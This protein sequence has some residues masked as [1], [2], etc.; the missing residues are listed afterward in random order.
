MPEITSPYNFVPPPEQTVY[1]AWAD[2]VSHDIPFAD[3]ICGWIE[4]EVAATTDLFV[5]GREGARGETATFYRDADGTLA[6]PGSGLRGMLR[7]VVEIAS[8][9]QLKPFNDQRFGFRDLHN[10]EDYGRHMAAIIGGEPMPLV[11][12]GWL[13]RTHDEEAGETWRIRPCHYAKAEY[14][15]LNRLAQ[16]L[17]VR[18]FNPDDKQS[19]VK[20]YEA[21]GARAFDDH[22]CP[23]SIKMRGGQ[24]LQGVKRLSDVGQVGLGASQL[25]RLVFTGQPQNRRA[26]ETRK[27]HHDFFFYGQAGSD[28]PVTAQQ[29]KDFEFIHARDRQQGKDTLEPNEEWSF[30][31]DRPGPNGGLAE[32]P[33]FFLLDGR[34]HVRALG[35]AMM[36]RLAYD[37]TTGEAVKNALPPVRPWPDL[38]ETIFGYVSEAAEDGKERGGLRGRVSIGAAR[39]VGQATEQ[40]AVEVVFGAPKA[41]YYPHYLQQGRS[42]DDLPSPLGGKLSWISYMSAEAKA[43]GWKR[44]L[45]RQAAEHHIQLPN[46]A[47]DEHKTRF[48]PLASGARFRARLRVHNLRPVELGALLWA[49]DFGGHPDA[50]HRLGRARP[51][52]FG[53]VRLKA[54]KSLLR[55]AD[56]QRT[57]ALSP[58]TCTRAFTGYM[59]AMTGDKWATSRTLF[60]LLKLAEPAP[61]GESI[62]YPVIGP[63]NEFND[64]KKQGLALM[65]RGGFNA[66]NAW[67]IKVAAT[68]ALADAGV[69]PENSALLPKTVKAEAAAEAPRQ[70]QARGPVAAKIAPTKPTPAGARPIV[71]RPTEARP[72]EAPAPPP[73]LEGWLEVRFLNTGDA[74]EA[75]KN[76]IKKPEKERRTA[77]I[78]AGGQTAGIFST[79]TTVGFEA[80]FDHL[81]SSNSSFAFFALFKGGQVV[82][83]ALTAP[84][85]GA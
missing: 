71:A 49:L 73:P 51:Y 40:R 13:V 82:E 81:A 61:K 53:S 6:V 50:V 36:F 41:S 74:R 31:R 43:R 3:G 8:F 69:W 48:K 35:L 68:P 32:V 42:I 20:K 64:I 84:A 59:Q 52:G 46:K 2:H 79:A 76:W 26:G 29:R 12:A 37:H 77:L 58:D 66:W 15:L 18:G 72:I 80:I 65:P 24:V 1:P 39:L 78:Q 19:S 60:E 4:V 45:P 16:Q 44:Y 56:G 62:R 63:P 47:K 38:A 28:L 11:N 9:S 25:G 70:V 85:E 5:G 17:G 33:V 34:G 54:G 67:R 23:V 75:R 30:W 7:S 22:N 55:W 14:G 27:K 21:W 57:E 83:V 10:R